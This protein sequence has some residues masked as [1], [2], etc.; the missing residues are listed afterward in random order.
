MKNNNYE[1][2]EAQTWSEIDSFTSERYMQFA[3]YIKEGQTILDVGCN[4]GRGGVVLKQLYP[5]IKLYG[6][7]LIEGRANKI[8]P[9]I[10]EQVFNDSIVYWNSNGIK[11]DRIIAGEL[12]EHIDKTDF[13]I[14]LNNCKDLLKDDG[15][16]LFT[17]PNPNSFLVK[18]GNKAV[19]ND[20]SHI[21]ILSVSQFKEKVKSCGLKIEK[22]VGSGKMT[23]YLKNFPVLNLYGSYLSILK[24]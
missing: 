6:I 12:I 1:N 21:N 4:T 24:K 16:I 22:I 19:F 11:F 3:S 14:M 2:N 13:L 20:P 9:N 15:L 7:D 10:Y 17:T 23:R 8:P 5:L 18:L